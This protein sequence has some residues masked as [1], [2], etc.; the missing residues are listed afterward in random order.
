METKLYDNIMKIRHAN[1]YS[2]LSHTITKTNIR[3]KIVNIKI[4]E[5]KES[6][7]T[8]RDVLQDE[9]QEKYQY[10]EDLQFKH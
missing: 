8:S 1:V 6:Q 9:S 10:R 3:H 7:D 5:K 2:I 4:L